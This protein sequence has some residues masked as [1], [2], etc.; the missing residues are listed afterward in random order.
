MQNRMVYLEPEKSQMA[1]IQV[2]EA[3]QI[4]LMA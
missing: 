4:K 2:A 1:E 3:P